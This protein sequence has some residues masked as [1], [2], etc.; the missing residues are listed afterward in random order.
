MTIE[1]LNLAHRAAGK[2]ATAAWERYTADP[3][4][5]NRKAHV[6]AHVA[7]ERAE[8]AYEDALADLP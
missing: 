5:R 7:L 4:E 2:A 1:E 8:N 6:Q 3:S